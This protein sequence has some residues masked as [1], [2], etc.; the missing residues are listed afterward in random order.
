MRVRIENRRLA[1]LV[2]LHHFAVVVLRD[3][4]PAI[5]GA[6]DAVAV[7]AGFLPDELPLL[8]CR[9]DAR[10]FRHRIV[11]RPRRLSGTPGPAASRRSPACT[12]ASGRRRVLARRDQ[13]RVAGI[14]CGLQRRRWWICRDRRQVRC[15]ALTRSE[16]RTKKTQRDRQRSLRLHKC[17]LHVHRPVPRRERR[18][19]ILPVLGGSPLPSAGFRSR[20]SA[21]P[22]VG[23]VYPAAWNLCGCETSSADSWWLRS[24]PV[25]SSCR[26]SRASAPGNTCW[27]RSGS[28]CLAAPA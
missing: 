28:G 11:P 13:G 17:L 26:P 15:L 20:R 25:R 23:I 9:N 14:G 5:I 1:S 12:P 22:S 7:V 6:D 24:L 2:E 8:P 21:G 10:D 4:Q 27:A 19:I 16:S 18:F 3:E